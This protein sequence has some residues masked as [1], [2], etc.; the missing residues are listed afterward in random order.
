MG[1]KL[2]EEMGSKGKLCACGF[3]FGPSILLIKMG[4]KK[5]NIFHDF[6]GGH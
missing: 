5:Q 6:I 1:S 4:G 2:N 3:T